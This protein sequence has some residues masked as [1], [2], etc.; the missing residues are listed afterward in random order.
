MTH[1]RKRSILMFFYRLIFTGLIVGKMTLSNH[2]RHLCRRGHCTRNTFRRQRQR[3]RRQW[4]RQYGQ[5]TIKH[6]LWAAAREIYRNICNC[7]LVSLF[8][9]PNKTNKSSSS[10]SHTL[11]DNTV[12][13]LTYCRWKIPLFPF[14]HFGRL[15]LVKECILRSEDLDSLAQTCAPIALICPQTVR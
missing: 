6:N 12:N 3:Q 4:Q 15:W 1:K 10:K 7:Q 13:Y 8:S 9:L 11:L 2:K 14:R 5:A